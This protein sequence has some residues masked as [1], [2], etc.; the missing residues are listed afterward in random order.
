MKSI[1]NS[2]GSGCTS[3]DILRGSKYLVES[4]SASELAY[5]ARLEPAWVWE[6]GLPRV[7]LPLSNSVLGGIGR[8]IASQEYPM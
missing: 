8:K 2:I 6:V 4:L 1:A 5:K 7:A 3:E